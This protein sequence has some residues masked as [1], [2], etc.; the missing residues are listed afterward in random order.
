MRR[1]LA[2]FLILAYSSPVLAQ[3]VICLGI[4]RS[5]HT[6]KAAV[7]QRIRDNVQVEDAVFFTQGQRVIFQIILNGN[8]RAYEIDLNNGRVIEDQYFLE[9]IS[10]KS[11]DNIAVIEPTSQML[12]IAHRVR[13]NETV[14]FPPTNQ[15]TMKPISGVDRVEL[16]AGYAHRNQK[17][18]GRPYT[19]HL[20]EVVDVLR[21]FRP[22]IIHMYGERVYEEAVKTAWL[23][24]VIE[25][26][27]VTRTDI[28][29]EFGPRLAQLADN[30][31]LREA[32]NNGSPQGAQ[33]YFSRVASDPVSSLVKVADRIAN[34]R[35]VNRVSNAALAKKYNSQLDALLDAVD[36]QVPLDMKLALIRIDSSLLALHDP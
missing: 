30:L 4:L 23:H 29:K 16:F 27:L 2:I 33:S 19:D 12:E 35:Q 28:T 10:H 11:A 20:Q 14:I 5:F 22:E 18:D 34:S 15:D 26:T 25:D 9:N 1:I 8:L 24:D 17:Y 36:T 13:K 6:I 32:E 21:S 7:F 3:P 31:S